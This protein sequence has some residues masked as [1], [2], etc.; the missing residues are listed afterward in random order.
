MKKA[1]FITYAKGKKINTN[2]DTVELKTIVN[3]G[4]ELLRNMSN[5]CL[6]LVTG[7]FDTVLNTPKANRKTN[8]KYLAIKKSEY[9]QSTSGK[10]NLEAFHFIADTPKQVRKKALT[11]LYKSMYSANKKTSMSNQLIRPRSLRAK[12]EEILNENKKVSV[13][14]A[15]SLYTAPNPVKNTA[16]KVNVSKSVKN[17]APKVIQQADKI[18]QKIVNMRKKDM[19]VFSDTMLKS[20]KKIVSLGKNKNTPSTIKKEI[21]VLDNLVKEQLK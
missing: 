1:T 10:K 18:A 12:I 20:W 8:E 21:G 15:T 14:Q 13:K 3:S 4:L 5:L 11:R 19:V 16:P 17:T 2:V 6:N 7:N 9:F